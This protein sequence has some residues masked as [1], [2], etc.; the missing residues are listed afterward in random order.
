[1][2]KYA[3][4]IDI[5]GTLFDGKTIHPE[6]IRA[7]NEA[8]RAGHFVFIN[9]GR[10]YSFIP[11]YILECADFYGVVAGIGAH[12]VIGGKTVKSVTVDKESL[13]QV[14]SVF[15][16]TDC[17]VR[18]QGEQHFYYQNNP[19]PKNGDGV[20]A[21]KADIDRLYDEMK[22]SKFTCY[23][24]KPSA[25]QLKFL[26]E[27]FSV[28][29]YNSSAEMTSK[30]QNKAVGML[31]AAKLVGVAPE[32]CIAMGDSEN[33]IDVLKVAGISVAMGNSPDEIK[34]I[35]DFV[36]T[37]CQDGGVAHAIDKLVLKK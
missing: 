31:D 30:G 5:D 32:N 33:D 10:G 16:D 23:N 22:I 29:E 7:I 3:I 28:V 15:A 25:K 18:Y 17:A 35:A 6:N 37:D 11:D 13:K 24:K 20:I 19:D 21:S 1:M 12:I 9:T 4:F 27:N 34:K 2:T 8:S 36:S 26:N 14:V